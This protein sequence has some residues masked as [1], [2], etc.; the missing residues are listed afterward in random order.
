MS[1]KGP[2]SL[3]AAF[4]ARRPFFYSG[5]RAYEC[6]GDLAYA[7]TADERQHQHYLRGLRQLRDGSTKTSFEA[8]RLRTSVVV[9][10]FLDR[11]AIVHS[12]CSR[13]P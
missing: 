13:R 10:E 12:V 11:L 4:R 3:S 6:C 1:K 2:D 9:E 7:E 5:V 8:G